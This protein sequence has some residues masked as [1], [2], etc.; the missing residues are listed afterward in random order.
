MHYMQITAQYDN[1]L[2]TFTTEIPALKVHL[3]ILTIPTLGQ[4]KMVQLSILDAFT[5]KNQQKH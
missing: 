2:V 1:L 3:M 5:E 4:K